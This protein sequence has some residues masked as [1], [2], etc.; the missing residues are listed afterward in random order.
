VVRLEGQAPD[1]TTREHAAVVAAS[2]AGVRAV[3]NRLTLPPAAA[4]IA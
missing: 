4:G 2:A 1:A 3:D